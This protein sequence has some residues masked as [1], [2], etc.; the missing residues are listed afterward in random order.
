MTGQSWADQRRNDAGAHE[1][2]VPDGHP[3]YERWQGILADAYFKSHD[4]PTVLFLDD[5]ELARMQ[6]LLDDAAGDLAN[7][8]RARLSLDAGRSMFWSISLDY[9][10]WRLGPKEIPPPVLPVLALSVLA[11]T[12]MHSD[13]TARSTNYYLR[14]A[15]A[16]T[17]DDSP[18]RI[19]GIREDLEIRGAFVQVVAMWK[20]LHEWIEGQN[21]RV[22]TSTIPANPRPS[23]IGYPLSQAI[24][25]KSDRAYLTRMF[26]VLDVSQD[27]V[28]DSE[29]M[30]RALDIWTRDSRNRF[31][32]AFMAALADSK[33]RPLVAAVVSAL[34]R[35]WDGRVLSRDGKQRIVMKVEVDLDRWQIRWLFPVPAS[36]PQVLSLADAKDR[37]R[38]GL[39]K[40]EGV[41]YYS[42][43]GAP[44]VTSARMSSGVDLRNEEFSASFP[45]ADIIFFSL[46]AETGAWSS[47]PGVVPFEDQLVAIASTRAAEF[48]ELLVLAAADGWRRIPQRRLRLLEGYDLFERVRFSDGKVFRDALSSFPGVRAAGVFQE[49][50]P[51]AKLVN[52]LPVAAAISAGHYLVGGA[53]DLLLPF[54]GEI[55]RLTVV[56]DGR[57]DI[58]VAN[59]FPFPIRRFI[60]GEGRHQID[61]GG[62]VL[63]FST[64]EEVPDSA[65]PAGTATLGWTAPAT[66]GGSNQ[67]LVIVGAVVEDERPGQF[68]LGRRG[69]EECWLLLDGGRSE[70]I[71]EPAPP[72][73]MSTLDVQMYS[74]VFEIESPATARWFAQRRGVRWHLVEIGAADSKEYDLEI[75]PLLAWKRSWSDVN[76][77]QLW[78]ALLS[79][80]GGRP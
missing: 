53:P 11:A 20:G 4:G 72:V 75:D 17:P 21:G 14:L 2:V 12:R 65:P 26:Q 78:K 37:W 42:A 23:R 30:M 3:A 69:R 55:R 28:L 76:G 5:D 13:L 80:A 18:A 24:V 58:V 19:E 66:M 48:E 60:E 62:Q 39:R 61:V 56:L 25:R 52:G 57:A 27:H 6:P 33:L 40:I 63:A 50:I 74:P 10:R 41:G 46:D 59:G 73:F 9:R 35:S 32:D 16:I 64:I 38:V 71:S 8:V 34:A 49:V 54:D 15:Q 77:A 43:F 45:P 67:E 29:D 79:T 1:E 31:S 68:V 51:R 47:V 36:G 70:R 7:A 22:G 44:P